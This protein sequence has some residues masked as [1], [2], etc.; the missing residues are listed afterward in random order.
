[1]V[2]LGYKVAG[3]DLTIPAG[4]ASLQY[5]PGVLALHGGHDNPFKGTPLE[6]FAPKTGEIDLKGYVTWGTGAP[7]WDV[8]G[9]MTNRVTGGFMSSTMAYTLKDYTLTAT[10]AYTADVYIAKADFNASFSLGYDQ[11]ARAFS[12][13]AGLTAHVQVGTDGFNLH[14]D[15]SANVNM[16]IYRGNLDFRGDATLSGGVTV[17]GISSDMSLSAHVDNHGFRFDLPGTSTDLMVRW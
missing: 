13:N 4:S 1:V 15:L 5:S 9:T 16:T 11:H 8:T 12:L 6:K 7:H 10:S 17:F 3:I 2:N 14:G